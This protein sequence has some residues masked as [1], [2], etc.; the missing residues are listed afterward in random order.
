[1]L[2][3]RIR[4]SWLGVAAVTLGTLFLLATAAGAQCRTYT[5]DADFDL[6]VLNGVN[7]D[8]PN[9]DQLQLSPTATTFPFA[10]IANA[11]EG[12]VSKVDTQTGRELARYRTGPNGANDS[13]SRTA[14][15]RDGNCWVANRAFGGQASIT[16]ILIDGGID[17]DGSSTIE[18]SSDLDND[19]VISGA[20]MLAWGA[21]ER[22]ARFYL[23]SGVNSVARAITIDKADFVWVGLFNDRRVVKV[24]PTLSTV[25]YA[26]LA[27]AAPPELVSIATSQTYGLATG[28]N[29]RLYLATLSNVA[30]EID[31]GAA[32][33][34]TDPPRVLQT[35]THS[36]QNYGIAVDGNNIVWYA[37]VSTNRV[38]RWD[39]S[40]GAAGFSYGGGAA[41]RGRGI[42]VD[43]DGNI[44]MA[45]DLASQV[46]KFSPGSPPVLMFNAGAGCNYPI[47]VGTA[48]DGHIV[49]VGQQS[50]S[51]GKVDKAT[52]ALI[53]TGGPQLTGPGPY[54][55]SDFTGSLRQIIGRQGF[56]TIVQ[57]SGSNG[58]EW[59]NVSWTSFEP[60]QT[61]VMVEARAADTV[62]GLESETYIAVANGVD[63]S[64]FGRHIQVRARLTTDR[65]DLESPIL[66]D[67][68]ICTANQP[69]V[70]DAGG[71][72]WA[73]CQGATTS[74]QLDGTGSSDPDGDA[75]TYAWTSDCPGAAFD[76][77]TSATPVLT[78]DT[79]C[80]CSIDCTVTLAV[81]DGREVTRCSAVVQIDD[82]TPPV[83]TP[84]GADLVLWPP[85]HKY[86][87]IPVGACLASVLDRCDQS[88]GLAS[89]HVTSVT[90]D[91]P[92]D[93]Q[94]NGDG[95]T[96]DDI[97]IA[98]PNSVQLRA[99]RQGG[100][101]HNGRVYTIHYEVADASGNVSRDTCKVSVP[102]DQSGD[103]AVEGPGPG[104]MVT[105]CVPPAVIARDNQPA[106]VLLRRDGGLGIGISFV[107]AEPG[108]VHFD[109]F[110]IRGRLVQH[111]S[112]ALPVGAHTLH[113][114][115]TDAA[116]AEVAAGIYLF[117]LQADGKTSSFKSVWAR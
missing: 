61:S 103:P 59:G 99:E 76:D 58:E 116:G 45:C 66:Y 39:P 49:A 82:T 18:T 28:A 50:N 104:Y 55:Y 4:W 91:E 83:I 44:W 36:G 2:Q 63:F 24:E 62:P 52:G 94:G 54:T 84:T 26:P 12:T 21:D 81:S 101:Q 33:L 114:N 8:P 32:S 85:N 102:H 74:L 25:T 68:T 10:W 75:L 105:T 37:D 89:V 100:G 96:L 87:N 7:H 41:S 113:W 110:D 77:A 65:A 19:G 112:P 11:S 27:N 3:N 98:C 78:V 15:D 35:Q 80:A 108:I 72:Y 56:W 60:D 86:H 6:G 115:G 40:L 69:P 34:G 13:P 30:Q 88:I 106:G 43:F 92:E 71:P 111:R 22:V 17:R 57:D 5:T 9:G 109:V 38:I 47:G 93:A 29:G 64:I 16:Q 67:L 42:T 31:P 20:E 48:A 97:R 46:A 90:S 117:R 107:L 23:I 79:S 1:M 14:V 95:K 73:E 51:W 53:V 70:C